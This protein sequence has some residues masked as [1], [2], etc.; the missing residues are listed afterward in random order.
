LALI[1]DLAADPGG[2]CAGRSCGDG[3]DLADPILPVFSQP[4]GALRIT[5]RIVYLARRGGRAV[6]CG[7]LENRNGA[8]SVRIASQNFF[9][10]AS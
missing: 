10:Q 7:G 1:D 2:G 8:I 3:R 4:S 6:Y 5:S 9:L